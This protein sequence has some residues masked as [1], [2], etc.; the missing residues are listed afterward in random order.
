VV[1]RKSENTRRLLDWNIARA[2]ESLTAAGAWRVDAMTDVP[3]GHFMGTARMGDDPATS[4]VDRWG[5]AHDVPNLAI[6]DGSVF[7]TAG[8]ANPTSTITALALR[9]AE[10]LVDRRR[11]IPIPTPSRS[12]AGFARAE[13]GSLPPA[14][15]VALRAPVLADSSRRRFERLADHL[16]PAADGMPSASE[17]AVG[18]A[19]LD[20][21]LAARP[22]LAPDLRRVL[23]AVGDDPGAQALAALDAEGVRTV[24]YLAAAAYYLLPLVREQLGYQPEPATPVR[25]LDYPEYLDEGLLDHLVDA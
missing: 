18:A 10:R 7:V 19:A 3:N 9:T 14:A 2:T 1:Y 4:V 12:T 22:D 8:S 5:V 16:I 13:T 21:A 6:V 17:A 11:D 24:R 15:P 20:Q 25:A 23:E